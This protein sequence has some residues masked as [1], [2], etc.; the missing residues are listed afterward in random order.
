MRT[1][2]LATQAPG[3]VETEP[4]DGTFV[5]W[6]T[7][8]SMV[9]YTQTRIPARYRVEMIPVPGGEFTFVRRKDSEDHV[10]DEGRDP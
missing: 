7:A 3:I 4:A 8:R 1:A 10:E 5:A 9:T 6:K 2:R